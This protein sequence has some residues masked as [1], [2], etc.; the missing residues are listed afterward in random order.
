MWGYMLQKSH[1]S[2]IFHHVFPYQ[3]NGTKRRETNQNLSRQEGWRETIPSCPAGTWSFC[4]SCAWPLTQPLPGLWCSCA[5][6]AVGTGC[7]QRSAGTGSFPQ[8]WIFSNTLSKLLSS[9]AQGWFP[10]FSLE[11]PIWNLLDWLLGNVACWT[12]TVSA[13]AP[14]G[15]LCGAVH[16]GQ[17]T[18]NAGPRLEPPSAPVKVVLRT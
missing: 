8:E 13:A 9:L 15:D 12:Y 11:N 6:V 1:S 17:V 18:Q 14:A 16:V 5:G 3:I 10:F 7:W 4:P 2:D